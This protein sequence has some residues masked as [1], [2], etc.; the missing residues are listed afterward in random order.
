MSARLFPLQLASEH[1]A[2]VISVE[3][4]FFGESLP[5]GQA[6]TTQTLA[7]H[8][9]RQAL[10][11]LARFTDWY[12]TAMIDPLRADKSDAGQN[13]W[14]T[15]GGSYPGA[16]SAWYRLKY[17]QWTVGSLAASGVVNAILEYTQ[18]D[19]QVAT[20]AGPECADAL[21][22]VTADIENGMPGV[23]AEFDATELDDG[24]FYFLAADAAA[25]SV[26]YGHHTVL[27]DAV[28]PPYQKGE[29]ALSAYASFVKS[30][31]YQTMGNA[32]SDYDSRIMADPVKGGNGRSWWWMKCTEF[33][34]FQVAPAKGS[35]R[36]S[37]VNL[38]YHQGVCKQ[39]F[40]VTALP[41]VNATNTYYGGAGWAG[42]NTYFSQGCEDP[43]QWAGIRADVN[44]TSPANVVQCDGCAHCA[45]LYTPTS[46]D[47]ATLVADR[48]AV[49]KNVAMWLG[50]TSH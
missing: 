20:S 41:D 14:F 48:E 44:P 47:A 15:V 42:S 5:F 21:R 6:L 26:Q 13:K 23:K 22:S 12:Q 49:A 4:R 11:D 2:L 27:C 8:N 50:G 39:L 9:S 43:W 36:S 28:V 10:A 46:S 18:F 40:G 31:F 34:F 1:G 17:P 29:S 3:H 38:A 16:L 35:I 33:A 45:D 7:Y 25:E 32:P 30:F 37:N 24:D 19:E